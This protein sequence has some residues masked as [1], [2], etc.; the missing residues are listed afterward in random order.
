[1]A[2][3]RKYSVTEIDRM[4]EAVEHKWLFGCRPSQASQ[5]QTMSS[6]GYMPSEKTKDVEELLRTYMIAGVEPE[7]LE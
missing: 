2:D 5:K 6:H 3:E 7:E 1:M 4:R